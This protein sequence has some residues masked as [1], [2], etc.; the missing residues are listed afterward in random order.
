MGCGLPGLS[1]H[2]R[3]AK[4]LALGKGLVKQLR[5]QPR[6]QSVAHAES[7]QELTH[8]APDSVG[9]ATDMHC[10]RLHA[11]ARTAAWSDP[12]AAAA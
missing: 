12:A 8:W 11:P 9:Q 5:A 3:S 2:T 1:P 6:L 4:C 10:Q 7:H